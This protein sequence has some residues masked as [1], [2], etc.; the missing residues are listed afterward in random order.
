MRLLV[1]LVNYDP[2]TSL[3]NIP[4]KLRFADRP[5]KSARAYSPDH[6]GSRRLALKLEWDH[7]TCVLPELKVYAVVAINLAG[8]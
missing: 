8:P 6:A 5:P 3:T 7:C 1:H 2:A 4:I